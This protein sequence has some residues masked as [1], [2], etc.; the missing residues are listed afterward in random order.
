MT[1]SAFVLLR[2]SNPVSP[3]DVER[4][5]ESHA[6]AA[7]I[8]SLAEPSDVIVP[9]DVA[10]SGRSVRS[11]LR[12]AVA[13]VSAIVAAIA[14]LVAGIQIVNRDD[15]AEV[16]VKVAAEPTSVEL[17][18][19]SVWVPPD[20]VDSAEEAVERF[21]H[22]VLATEAEVDADPATRADDPT[23]VTIALAGGAVRA[24]CVP[25]ADRGW[26]IIQVG[27][28]GAV[29][30]EGEQLVLFVDQ[31]PPGTES[32]IVYARDARATWRLDV[33]D[34]VP[35]GRKIELLGVNPMELRSTIA[36]FIDAT[37][38]VLSAA[39]GFYGSAIEPSLDSA[40]FPAT[41]PS[42]KSAT[43]AEKLLPVVSPDRTL[44]V[45]DHRMRL[46]ETEGREGGYVGVRFD[47]ERGNHAT[48]RL[49]T[50]S[51]EEVD[52]V[53]SQIDLSPN[54]ARVDGQGDGSDDGTIRARRDTGLLSNFIV[55]TPGPRPAM[56]VAAVSRPLVESQ[57]DAHYWEVLQVAIASAPF[58]L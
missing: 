46:F 5:R 7:R 45:G 47:D 54:S 33:D 28:P 49:H 29:R 10:P 19:N 17:G 44:V 12:G 42:P 35:G 9:D 13:A 4:W 40:T 50:A 16:A 32:A 21:V 2:E 25:D 24:L 52:S 53:L 20:P 26:K 22:D 31:L 11:P 48:V 3:A 6:T 34:T 38:R 51:S 43:F 39:G 36:M 14:V 58:A 1:R 57:S 30:V 56:A 18:T 27:Q 8:A 15:G 55:I 41:E 37:G 23:W